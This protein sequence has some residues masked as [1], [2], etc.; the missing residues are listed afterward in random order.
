M[1]VSETWATLAAAPANARLVIKTDGA[2]VEVK[3]VEH[4]AQLVVI[5]PARD[6]TDSSKACDDLYEA[7]QKIES[8]QEEVRELTAALDEARGSEE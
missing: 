6:L 2:E 7:Q 5:T 3:S 1:N 8:L 4:F